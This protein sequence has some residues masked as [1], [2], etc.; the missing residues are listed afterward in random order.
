MICAPITNANTHTAE[1][2]AFQ[3]CVLSSSLVHWTLFNVMAVSHCQRFCEQHMFYFKLFDV[4]IG[5]E[6]GHEIRQ[7][8]SKFCSSGTFKLMCSMSSAQFFG[9][10]FILVPSVIVENISFRHAYRISHLSRIQ[11]LF[12]WL[13]NIWDFTNRIHLQKMIVSFN[14]LCPQ[15]FPSPF[16]H[17]ISWHG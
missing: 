13:P 4:S 17:M 2:C 8:I 16:P 6:R 11:K 15:L 3:F 1:T 14:A 5:R 10:L 7:C 9:P 12:V